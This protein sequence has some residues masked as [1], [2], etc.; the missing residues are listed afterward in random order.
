MFKKILKSRWFHIIAQIALQFINAKAGS[1]V[2]A[3]IL[4]GTTGLYVAGKTITD[5]AEAK[6]RGDLK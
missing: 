6:F 3:E 4:A 5:I 1:P 2:N